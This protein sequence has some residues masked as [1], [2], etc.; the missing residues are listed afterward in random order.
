M[1]LYI[2]IDNSK[3]NMYLCTL[4]NTITMRLINNPWLDI[5]KYNCF[6]CCPNNP[7]G[8]Q[9]RFYEDGDDII[10]IWHPSKNYQSWI[11]TIHGGVQAVLIDEVCGWVV[12]HKLGLTGM[13]AKMEMRYRKPMVMDQEYIIAR[14]SLK[15]I[16]HNIAT[17]TAELRGSNRELLVEG[18]CTYYTF[19]KAH[20]PENLSC[21]ATSVND[22][23]ISF[24][25]V[26]KQTIHSNN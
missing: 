17:I 16:N 25:E 5:P 7:I 26:I 3:N 22:E 15:N 12:F 10:A 9:L 14:A 2:L 6:G 1:F 11:N 20:L 4:N 24:E 8:L 18:S 13:T 23:D 21:E 19:D